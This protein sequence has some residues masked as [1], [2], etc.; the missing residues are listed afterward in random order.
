MTFRRITG[1]L[2]AGLLAATL[3]SVGGAPTIADAQ[4]PNVGNVPAGWEVSPEPVSTWGVATLMPS[5]TVVFESLVWD[6]AEIDG[7]VYVAGKFGNVQESYNAPLQN[8]AY[9]A[10][11][12]ADTG[13]WIPSFAPALDAGAFSLETDG[14]NLF[15][16]GE[17]TSINGTATGP[18]AA[19]NPTTG[20]VVG[21]FD[22]DL[23]FPAGTAVVMD[24]DIANGSLYA[25]GNFAFAGTDIAV[26]L[27]KLDLT[28]GAHDT[29]F[30]AAASGARVWTLEASPTGDRVYVGGYFEVLNGEPHKWF[31]ALDGLTGELVPGVAQG[32]PEGMPNCC[33]Q[34]PF[35]IAV[36]GDKVFVA[37]ESHLLEVLNENDLSRVGYYLTSFGGGDYQ[38]A[39][40]VGDRLYTGGHFWANQGY[41]EDVVPFTNAAWQQANLDTLDD[42]SQTHTIWSAAFDAN[43]G[44]EIPSYLMDMGMK[45]GIWAIHGSENGRL[46]LGGDVS[47]AGSGW[48]GGFATFAAAPTTER[49]PLLSQNQPA[50]MSSTRDVF[51]ANYAVDRHLAGQTRH[52]GI[53]TFYAETLV[54][55]NPWIE[56]DLGSV[57]QVG[58]VRLFERAVGNFNGMSNGSL[59]LSDVPFD[60]TDPTATRAQAGVSTFDTGNIGRWTDVEVFSSA[61]YVRYQLPGAGRQL[62][63]DNIE[64]FEQVGNGPVLAAPATLRVTRIENRRVVLNYGLV[65]AADSYEILRDGVVVGT[66]DNGWFVDTELDEGTTYTYTARALDAGGNPGLESVSVEATTLGGSLAAPAFAEVTRTEARRVVVRYGKVPG[67]ASHQ[68]LIDGAVVGT[69]NDGWYTATGLEPAT[70]YSI[71]VRGVSAGGAIGESATVSVTTEGITL[72]APAF[73]NV[74]RTEMRKI[75]INYGTVNGASTHEILVNG[76]AVGTDNDRWFTITDLEPGTT[77]DIEVRAVGADG[78]PG[79]TASVIGTTLP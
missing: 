71:E 4:A 46:W 56:I 28:T 36:H 21:S 33:K 1:A 42:P 5:E 3:T 23:T 40:V 55:D 64:V 18:L 22:A 27:A 30:G 41:S 26:R 25:G 78:T 24:L 63:V 6:F 58:V 60:S 68:I 37:R 13:E 65:A 47:R 16:G 74:T 2:S 52:D 50:T 20:A 38:A 44:E 62:T 34:N 59:Y 51:S 49:G 77:Y 8:Q 10:A 73:L 9:L 76:V 54:E 69:D 35:D 67:A 43:S 53:R 17:F 70:T 72:G 57:Q 11:F 29:N 12:D 39:E 14:T 32:T 19:L 7:V 66:D 31:G 75:V 45:S 15:V 61:R 48:A 79:P